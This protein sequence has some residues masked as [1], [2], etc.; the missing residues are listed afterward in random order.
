[1]P[2]PVFQ[3]AL[4]ITPTNTPVAEQ[5]GENAG[6]SDFFQRRFA[7][8]L[9]LLLLLAG[10]LYLALSFGRTGFAYAEA[11]FCLIPCEMIAAGNFVSPL[12]HNI[13]YYDKPILSYWLIIPV[14]KV[15]GAS[16]FTSRIP[17]VIYALCT[18]GI[19]AL[20]TRRLSG[21][22]CAILSALALATSFRFACFASSSMPDMLL[23]LLDTCT[24][25]A[26]YAYVRASGRHATLMALAGLCS[27]LAFLT[28]G[29]I[30][31]VLP[32]VVFLAYLALSKQLKLLNVRH[33]LLAVI[34]CLAAAL[35]WHLAAVARDGLGALQW[36][37]VTG[38]VQRFIGSVAGYNFD[39][40]PLYMPITTLTGFLP[41]T[42]LLPPIVVA[43][44]RAWRKNWNQEETSLSLYLWLWIVANVVFFSLSKS[45]WGYYT[46]PVYP[47]AAILVGTYMA[48][49]TSNK[50]RIAKAAPAI[51]GVIIVASLVF[52]GYA[53]LK[54]PAKA[55]P[56]SVMASILKKQSSILSS[57]YEIAVESDLKGQ[58]NL[59]E[60]IR[61]Q[62]GKEVVGFTTTE[63]AQRVSDGKPIFCMLTREKFE[64]LPNESK[65]QLQVVDSRP[66]KLLNYPSYKMVELLLVTNKPGDAAN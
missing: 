32:G 60:L 55:D 43:S 25:V 66:F 29:P 33:V 15:L 12:F 56:A 42:V 44:V 34:L 50:P 57:R 49:W 58:Y 65:S 23:V 35:P 7:A 26:L 1:M 10:C 64:T 59:I 40:G 39:H 28:K 6:Q 8:S 3:P 5:S 38:N 37:Y 62:V 30:G 4:T 16:L 61:L 27:G 20:C 19:V 22:K 14:Y 46:L 2:A 53:I 47:A 24:M 9:T 54:L 41:W 21:G 52:S 63:L 17:S 45:N 36:L 18:I 31:V 11:P 48:P 51:F 13:P